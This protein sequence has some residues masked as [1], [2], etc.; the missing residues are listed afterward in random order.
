MSKLFGWLSG[1]VKSLGDV[2]RVILLLWVVSGIGLASLVLPAAARFATSGWAGAFVVMGSGL[3]LAGG[4]VLVGAVV[5]F[6]FGVPRRRRT[7]AV[8]SQDQ[9]PRLDSDA[10]RPNTNLE[11][12]SDWLTKIIVGIG[13]TQIPAIVAFF[14]GVA[15]RAG[16]AFGDWPSGQI[17]AISLVIHYLLVGFFQGFLLAY[18]WLPGA[19][20]RATRRREDYMPRPAGAGTVGPEA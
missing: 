11:Q 2:D 16:P 19:F 14:E 6:L 12:I 13:L 9:Q 15:R 18:L 4:A 10:Y 17:I 20:E 5:G 3:F 7:E 1:L 8:V